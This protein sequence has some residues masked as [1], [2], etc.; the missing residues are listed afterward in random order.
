MPTGRKQDDQEKKSAGDESE[1]LERR[2]YRDAQGGVHHH[3]RTSRQY[4]ERKGEK[5]A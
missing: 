2:E 1:E 4:H 3:T 5:K